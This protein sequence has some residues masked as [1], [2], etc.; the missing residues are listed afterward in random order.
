MKVVTRQKVIQKDD[1]N[2]KSVIEEW[3]ESD[4]P[5]ENES[6]RIIVK[7]LSKL[8]IS[9]SVLLEWLTHK[10]VIYLKCSD[11]LLAYIS[12]NWSIT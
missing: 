4:S 7:Y 2:I 11:I 1:Q 3:L 12:D 5:Y 9:N 6:A 8:S 10:N